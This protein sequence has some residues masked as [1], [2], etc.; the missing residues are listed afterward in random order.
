MN[1]IGRQSVV[2]FNNLSVGGDFS[3]LKNLSRISLIFWMVTLFL[4]LATGSSKAAA[5]TV[6][7]GGGCA[8]TTIQAGI[9]NALSGDT[10]S[11]SAG[12]YSE[13]ITFATAADNITLQGAGAATTKIQGVSGVDK[14]V[15]TFSSASTSSLTVLDG[16]TIDNQYTYDHTGGI[17]ISGGASPTLRNLTISGN[18]LRNSGSDHF[19]GGIKITGSSAT[20]E[21]CTISNNM[22]DVG[23]GGVYATTADA[24]DVVTITDSIITGNWTQA[25]GF[26]P[27][28]GGGVMAHNYTGTVTITNTTI[29]SNS[30]PGAYSGKGGGVFCYN[31]A[32]LELIDSDVTNNSTTRT[33]VLD[34][35]GGIAVG[36][37]GKVFAT[38]GNVSSNRT[39]V[40][41]GGVFVWGAG[42]E[43]TGSRCTIS[44]NK[45]GSGGG[46]GI[47]I[48][49]GGKV[50]L[51]NCMVTGNVTGTAYN[52]HAGGISN[53]FSTTGYQTGG[54]LNINHSTISGNYANKCG[55]GIYT[56]GG[57]V[58]TIVGTLVWDN[59]NGGAIANRDTCKGSGSY[60]VT[61]SGIKNGSGFVVGTTN[62]VS[63]DI[64][65]P[66]FV[67]L[68]QAL[69]V[70]SPQTGGDF[71]LQ[72]TAVGALDTADPL[73]TVVE[74]YDVHGR[75][76]NVI[77]DMGSD[78][79]NS[80]P[81]GPSA[82]DHF[83]ITYNDSDNFGIYCSAGETIS[84]TPKESGGADYANYTGTIVLDT[85]TGK[86]SWSLVQG[87]GVFAD[88]TANDGL[89]TYTF[90][91]SD[92]YPVQFSLDY[93]E[94]N[95]GFDID[96]YDQSDSLIRDDDSEGGIIYSP[97]GFTIT[98]NAL[99]NPPPDPINDPIQTQPK[100]ADFSVHITAYSYTDADPTCGVI[101]GYTGTKSLKFWSA[102]TGVF[103]V[104]EGSIATTEAAAISQI[105]TFTNGQAQVVA[106]Y[107]DTGDISFTVK[108][109]TV[110]DPDL[111][112]GD[113][114]GSSNLFTVEAPPADWID[115]D[116]QATPF[117]CF[118][119]YSLGDFSPTENN[120]A[121]TVGVAGNYSGSSMTLQNQDSFEYVLLVGGDATIASG[122]HSAE[123]PGGK[124]NVAGNIAYIGGGVFPNDVQSGGSVTA[125]SGNTQIAGNLY[126]ATTISE[127]GGILTVSGLQLPG[128]PYVP[129]VNHSAISTYFKDVS[130]TV[131]GLA[132]TA[133]TTDLYGA[134]SVTVNSGN[135]VTSID[136]TTLFN[137]YRFTVTGPSD[138]VLYVNVTGST[139]PSLN[140]TEW[141]YA[142]GIPAT[143]V[144]LNYP[145][146]NT[147][148]LTNDNNV[149][150]LAPHTVVDGSGGYVVGNL[151]VGDMINDITMVLGH[152]I[153]DAPAAGD[154]L[155]Y[156]EIGHD[157]FGINCVGETISV[158]PKKSDGSDFEGH[159]GTIVLDTQSGKGSWI[160]TNGNGTLT[161]VT[162]NDGLATYTF[163]GTETLPVTF[164]LEYKE[165]ASVINIDVYD[166]GDNTLRDDDTE[167]DISFM[168]NG[169][170]VDPVA[171][172]I[173]GADIALNITAYG[174]TASD[175]LCG[176]IETYTGDKSIKFWSLYSNPASGTKQVTI[177]ASPIAT[178][179]AAATGQD[180]V[181]SN[182]T[183]Q[184]AAKYKDAGR[185]VISMKDE[186]VADPE[187]PAGIRGAT[188][189]FVSKP[190]DFVLSITANLATE[191]DCSTGSLFNLLPP[192][193]HTNPQTLPAGEDFCVEVTA[194]DVNGDATP[195]FGQESTGESVA[196]NS[197]IVAPA[198][199][200]GGVE[201]GLAITTDFDFT[202]GA[203]DGAA[204]GLF[205]WTEVG[206]TNLTA[207]VK[208]GD[209]L[210]AGT[211][212]DDE[213]L[214][215]PV[216]VG[217][218][219]PASFSV[220]AVE[221]EFKAACQAGQFTYIGESFN[222]AITPALTLT[223]LNTAGGT[224]TN[225]TLPDW[226]KLAVNVQGYTS[227]AGTVLDLSNVPAFPAPLLNNGV[228]SV[229]FTDNPGDLLSFVRA[230]PQDAFR[231]QIALSIGLLDSD[232]VPFE[233]GPVDG[234]QQYVYAFG[235]TDA[236]N[237]VSF[238]VNENDKQMLYGRVRIGN[239]LGSELLDLN[240]PVVVERFSVA[241]GFQPNVNDSCTGLT[242]D[243]SDPDGPGVG[244][245][246]PAA[247]VAPCVRESGANP[248]LSGL[249]C[250]AAVAVPNYS[251]PPNGGDFNVWLTAPLVT[252][253]LDLTTDALN[254][255]DSWLMFDWDGD[256]N[257]D[258]PQGRASFGLYRGES[259]VIFI[260]E[261][262]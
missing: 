20:I 35:G 162:A 117:A 132:N 165:G 147:L 246:K 60:S 136:A 86:G 183:A 230:A 133:A 197:A 206:I 7:A 45:V 23:G 173:A 216:P 68:V 6:C 25:G 14:R 50:T 256:G 16:F 213:H 82:P 66:V 88:A 31:C 27:S 255:L 4:L 8:Y 121:G 141:I 142:G 192:L 172:Q 149:N 231:A 9:D 109:D 77:N 226:Y 37:G 17:I 46:G 24:S 131:G 155:D 115:C 57:G 156:F 103:N 174:Q 209:Y 248:G 12:V 41:S 80:V 176:V 100:D 168:P 244:L 260:R 67:N 102:A 44:G 127:S 34:M 93:K 85:Q 106:S 63:G 134:L 104:D 36:G 237:G 72:G 201:P 51:T 61:Y 83:V 175:P 64:T 74:D 214:P 235:G 90:D 144:L 129:P 52:S 262:R 32:H 97:T 112:T 26:A 245:D 229:N 76:V 107:Y 200:D 250:A 247:G 258:Q 15:V 208:D 49:N 47:G 89:A 145:N 224:T 70:S 42:S 212:Y 257:D 98:A 187:I 240:M 221:P 219:I 164:T 205:N 253:Y 43:F 148:T 204:E 151:I 10:I 207:E 87:A 223:A 186:N 28:G 96:V 81:P 33:T 53:G 195:G 211:V 95:A 38:G 120:I 254:P 123:Y 22:G 241:N 119:F 3:G 259:S 101:E 178:G 153:P 169:F 163:S 217:R 108:D 126:A 170:I 249:S 56:T 19:G 48:Y 137:A 150:I 29:D 227:A 139:A 171:T 193:D 21:N 1:Q 124:H 161:D 143:H 242:L 122:I 196:L 11:V 2:Q 159:T 65:E 185:I 158:W 233:G 94:G 225:Y 40:G 116:Y 189:P 239:A 118:N 215:V 125:I 113:I 181:F 146:A 55:G 188:N 73:S 128:Y 222:Y 58:T 252:G 54:T 138:A 152:F 238:G 218:F 202:E 167:G 190:A 177:N 160:A 228:I 251:E 140:H 199:A 84:V 13:N 210:G 198:V 135:N 243:L 111:P 180:V 191:G 203:I 220:V 194:V 110:P 99:T 157:G 130:T 71:H 105:V 236:P 18:S 179:E 30:I 91:A 232:D 184:V 78:E 92:V 182:G 5:V 261:V 154:T 234:S 39:T 62:K 75:P 59:K 114:R 69:N 166:Q 79:Y